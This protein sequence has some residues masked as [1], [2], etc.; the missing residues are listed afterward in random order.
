MSFRCGRL[1]IHCGKLAD[2][3]VECELLKLNQWRPKE[4]EG[5]KR[6]ER[7]PKLGGR[8]WDEDMC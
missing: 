4:D 3:A 2:L 8:V 6:G 1:E 7:E 5:A